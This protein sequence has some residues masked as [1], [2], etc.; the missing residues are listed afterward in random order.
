[1]IAATGYTTGLERLVGHLG[2]LDQRGVPLIHGGPAA[3]PGLR[4][5]GYQPRPAQIRY[6][7]AEAR[8]AAKQIKKDLSRSAATARR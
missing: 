6:I 3:A 7:G 8:R 5:I 1:V 4:F 2:V